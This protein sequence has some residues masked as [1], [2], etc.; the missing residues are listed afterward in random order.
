MTE[1]I[2]KLFI[3]KV[4]ISISYSNKELQKILS[5]SY[6]EL[7]KPSKTVIS[8]DKP[9]KER[10]KRER[11]ENGE[12]IKKRLPSAYN[13][14]IKNAS[15]KIREENPG[16]NSKDVFKLAI[17]EWNKSKEQNKVDKSSDDTSDTII[18][19]NKSDVNTD[20]EITKDDDDTDKK[21]F[22][23]VIVKPVMAKKSRKS[24]KNVTDDE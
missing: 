7:N 21:D 11:D 8:R 2:I 24:K 9:R 16:L 1:A 15:V 14:F 22:D 3:S 19:N 20:E 18:Q 6:K 4:D 13:I 17:D 5:D 23:E 10:V 12:I